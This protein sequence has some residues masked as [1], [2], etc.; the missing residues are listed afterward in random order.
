MSVDGNAQ[1]ADRSDSSE[2][3]HGSS[4]ID[5]SLLRAQLRRSVAERI[6]V[7][8]RALAQAL[9]LRRAVRSSHD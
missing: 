3:R 7:H 5:K 1:A 9:L 2:R 6:A 8:D 4:A